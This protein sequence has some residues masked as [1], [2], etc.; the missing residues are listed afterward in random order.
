[1]LAKCVDH[2]LSAVT[3]PRTQRRVLKKSFRPEGLAHIS[4]GWS[5]FRG[6]LG[7]QAKGKGSP[8]RAADQYVSG[9]AFQAVAWCEQS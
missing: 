1:M 7:C 4:P 5:A 2:R 3:E 8:E 9:Q 6:G